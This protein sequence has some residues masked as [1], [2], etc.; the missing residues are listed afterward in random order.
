MVKPQVIR[1]KLIEAGVKNLK[2]FGY[3]SVDSKNILTDVVY[4]AF[5]IRM[6]KDNLG[7]NKDID[8]EINILLKE[9]KE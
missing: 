6:L 9:I 3:P 5:F 4:S 7:V 2:E 8:K 1:E